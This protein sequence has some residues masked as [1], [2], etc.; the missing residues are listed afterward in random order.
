MGSGIVAVSIGECNALAVAVVGHGAIGWWYWE[1]WSNW[2]NG[3]K[4]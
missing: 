3:I 1:K 2:D 4:A